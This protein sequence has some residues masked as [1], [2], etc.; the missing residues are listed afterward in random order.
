MKR[1]IFL[2]VS[3]MGAI[4]AIAGDTSLSEQAILNRVFREADGSLVASPTAHTAQ[5]VLNATF[6]SDA[7]ALNISLVAGGPESE[8]FELDSNSDLQPTE[9]GTFSLQWEIDSNHDIQP[10]AAE[11]FELDN[12]DDL[13]PQ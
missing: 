8:V 10:K 6:N 11:S 3:L 7:D 2:V 12:N 5:G 13:Q 9:S 1:T 4:P